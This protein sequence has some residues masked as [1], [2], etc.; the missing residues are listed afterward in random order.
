[1]K[2]KPHLCCRRD[3]NDEAAGL[4]IDGE[5]LCFDHLHDENEALD[6]FDEPAEIER[7]S[8]MRLARAH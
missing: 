1:M 3:C 4:S 5:P 6:L 7:E 8:F 2:T